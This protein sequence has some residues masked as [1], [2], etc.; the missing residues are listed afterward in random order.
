[1]LSAPKE[2]NYYFP[3]MTEVDVGK[4]W[5]ALDQTYSQ[6]SEEELHDLAGKA[7][8]LTDI[9]KEAL[10]AQISSR[11]LQLELRDAPPDTPELE[12]GEPQGEFD[13]AD[14]TLVSVA[15]VWDADEARQLMKSLHELGF[16]VYLG[17]EN[18]ENVDDFH[19]KF[20]NGLEVRVRDVDQQRALHVLS[21]IPSEKNAEEEDPEENTAFLPRC[22]KCHSEEIVFEELVAGASH[23]GS[24]SP[25]KFRWHCDACGNDWEDDGVGEQS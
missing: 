17:P 6:M 19:S 24:D 15:E 20:D 21:L 10:R 13:P 7:Y 2:I 22:P 4:E 16:P 5:R 11:G 1:M 25:Q 23:R 12:E 9:A 3:S 8:E 18:L 14:L